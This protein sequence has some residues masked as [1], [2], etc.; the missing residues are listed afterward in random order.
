MNDVWCFST[1]WLSAATREP[2][3]VK[4]SFDDTGNSYVID[5]TQMHNVLCRISN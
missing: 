2:D 3:N 5:D 4:Y 1:D